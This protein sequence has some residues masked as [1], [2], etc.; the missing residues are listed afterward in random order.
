MKKI[1]F[2]AIFTIATLIAK[3]QAIDFSKCDSCNSSDIA[4]LCAIRQTF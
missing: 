1:T 4:M 2:L 3:S